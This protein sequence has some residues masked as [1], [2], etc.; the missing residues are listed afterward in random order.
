MKKSICPVP[1]G[2]RADGVSLHF[3]RG[4]VT[5]FDFLFVFYL[6]KFFYDVIV[7]SLQPQL[8]RQDPQIFFHGDGRIV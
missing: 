2:T 3:G 4:F 7:F 8:D 5:Y 6:Y 1:F